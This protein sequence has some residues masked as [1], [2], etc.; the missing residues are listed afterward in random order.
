M[1]YR[2]HIL[3]EVTFGAPDFGGARFG[4]RV[5][6]IVVL[7]FPAAK[8]AGQNSDWRAHSPVFRVL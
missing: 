5:A 2:S 4:V 3:G 7:S 8:R 6:N 1:A